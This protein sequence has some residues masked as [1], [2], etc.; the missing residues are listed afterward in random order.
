VHQGYDG[1]TT[2]SGRLTPEV[3][4][5]LSAA[6]SAASRPDA[7]GEIRLPNQRKADALESVLDTVL[8]NALLPM[9]GGEKPHITLTVDLDQIRE[10]A[11]QNEHDPT[12]P[13]SSPW[14]LPVEQRTALV[15][16]AVACATDSRPHYFWT[17]TASA[18]AAR[19]LSCDGILLPIFTRGGE[20]VDVGRRTRV[21]PSPLRALILARDCHC[22]WPDCTVPGRWT[23]VHHVVHWRDGGRTDRW[24]LALLCDAHHRAAHSGRFTVVLE[25]PGKIRVEPRVKPSDPYYRIKAPPSAQPGLFEGP[26]VTAKLEAYARAVSA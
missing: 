6:L 17:G 9:D 4:E 10:R 26:S 18:A 2:I 11:A 5:K 20:P 13:A 25:G 12:Q 14:A 24:N 15:D 19:R 1:M 16:A 3:G 8:D 22:Q 7:S 23:Q 21:I